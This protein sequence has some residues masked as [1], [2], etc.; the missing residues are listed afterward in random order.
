MRF[1]SPD[2][3]GVGSS[4][5][6]QRSQYCMWRALWSCGGGGGGGISLAAVAAAAKAELPKLLPKLLPLPPRL[7]EMNDGEVEDMDEG[8]MAW[9]FAVLFFFLFFFFFFSLVTYR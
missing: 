8:G 4:V 7:A 3:Y 5:R 1:E 2:V 6:R 9:E